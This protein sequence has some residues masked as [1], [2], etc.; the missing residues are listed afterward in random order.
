MHFLPPWIESWRHRFF[1]MR[2]PG[3]GNPSYALPLQEGLLQVLKADADWLKGQWEAID[4]RIEA[5]EK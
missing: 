5:L 2:Q 4:K 1:V 3:W